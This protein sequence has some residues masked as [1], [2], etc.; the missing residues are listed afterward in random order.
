MA[1][2]AER[3]LARLFCSFFFVA[4][5]LVLSALRTWHAKLDWQAHEW[6]GVDWAVIDR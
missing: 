3:G 2:N 4:E 1:P 5:W 6:S